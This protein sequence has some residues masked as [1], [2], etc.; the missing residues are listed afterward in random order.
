MFSPTKEFKGFYFGIFLAVQREFVA[1]CVENFSK[2]PMSRPVFPVSS[3]QPVVQASLEV[4][5][6]GPARPLIF[7]PFLHIPDI[8]KTPA[9]LQNI[10]F[11]LQAHVLQLENT[12]VKSVW[13]DQ[14]E[15]R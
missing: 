8:N 10:Y 5:V 6:I 11:L 14:L 4:V 1:F 9:M 12:L 13:S 2:E 3:N 7:H 15:K